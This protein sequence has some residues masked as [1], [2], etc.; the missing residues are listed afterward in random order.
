VEGADLNTAH[1]EG[2][3]L[4]EAHLEG[5]HLGE[6]QLQGAHLREAHLEGTRDLTV[7]QLSTVK[8][9]YLALLDP[10]LLEQIQQQYPQLLE[11]PRPWAAIF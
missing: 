11:D 2:A 1:L 4:G 7:A 9:L 6:A 3:H 10:P 5:A 8:T